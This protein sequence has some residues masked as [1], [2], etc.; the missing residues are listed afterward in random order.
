VGPFCP[1]TPTSG[2][3]VYVSEIMDVLGIALGFLLYMSG[4]EAKRTL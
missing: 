4:M 1:V 3:P 2:G